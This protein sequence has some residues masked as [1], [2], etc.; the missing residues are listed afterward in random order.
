MNDTQVTEAV[1]KIVHSLTDQTEIHISL[2]SGFV[3]ML[4]RR[5]PINHGVPV[6][7]LW[8]ALNEAAIAQLIK[9]RDTK[10]N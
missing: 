10:F 7:H 5:Y 4:D 3:Q 9:E 6:L 2:S 8:S 1:D